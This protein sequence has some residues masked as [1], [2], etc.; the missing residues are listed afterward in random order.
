VALT[1]KRAAAGG[2]KTVHKWAVAG[3]PADDS[4]DDAVVA[5]LATGE[6]E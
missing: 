3:A 2:G 6:T 4:E 1:V 5:A